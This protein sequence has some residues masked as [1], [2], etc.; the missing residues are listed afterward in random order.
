LENSEIDIVYISLPIGMHEEWVKKSSKAGKHILCEKSAVLSLNSAK[1]VLAQCRK[2]NVRLKEAFAYKF[3]PQHKKIM[4]LIHNKKMNPINYLFVKFG[5]TLNYHPNNFRFI[6]K[7]GGG[8]L[9]DVGCYAINTS[10]LYFSKQP[11]SIYCNLVNNKKHDI[12][13]DGTIE[14]NYLNNQ[15]T[16]GIFSYTSYFQSNYTLWGRNGFVTS[17]RAYNIKNNVRAKIKFEINESKKKIWVKS[18]DQYQN[19]IESFIDEIESKKMNSENE[20]LLQAKMMEA[21]RLSSKGNKP[22]FLD[23][24]K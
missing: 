18:S 16:L 8:V 24:V 6:K 11:V 2:N 1:N 7:L 12:D 21:A 5:F 14:I 17:L 15:K 10:L 22:I 3:H 9:N 13:V 20:F 23:S 19:M 4:N